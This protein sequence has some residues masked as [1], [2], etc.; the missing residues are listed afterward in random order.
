MR[1][2][3]SIDFLCSNFQSIEKWLPFSNF[4]PIYRKMA[5]D[6]QSI[7]KWRCIYYEKRTVFFDTM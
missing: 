2:C 1:K 4:F 7:E 5:A 3:Q 6:F